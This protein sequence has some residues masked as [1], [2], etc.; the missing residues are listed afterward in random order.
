MNAAELRMFDTKLSA[1]W[2][3]DKEIRPT[4]FSSD[5]ANAIAS[6]DPAERQKDAYL[7]AVTYC[8]AVSI[9]MSKIKCGKAMID[10]IHEGNDEYMPDYPPMSP[11]THS[12]FYSRAFMT[13]RFG[14]ESETAIEKIVQL[15]THWKASAE[16]INVMR[17][18]SHSRM[19]IF[20]TIDIM[21]QFI[22][23]RELLTE[24]EFRLQTS[25]PHRAAVGE[26]RLI[27][28]AVPVQDDEDC[29]FEI[30]TPYILR[31]HSAEQWTRCLESDLP[32]SD[33]RPDPLYGPDIEHPCLPKSET[34]DML[35]A[36]FEN[37]CGPMPWFEFVMDGYSTHT[38][39]SITLSGIPDRLETLPHN[40]E[41]DPQASKRS[42]QGKKSSASTSNFQYDRDLHDEHEDVPEEEPAEYFQML[43][44]LFVNSPEFE[45]LDQDSAEYSHLLFELAFDYIGKIPARFSPGDFSELLFQIIP[46]KVS[47][48]SDE[49]APLVKEFKAFFDF[50]AREFSSLTAARLSTLCDLSAVK[51]L[52]SALGDSSNFGMAKSFFS[53]GAA[54]GFDMTSQEELQKFVMLYNAHL[55]A[56]AENRQIDD[57]ENDASVL[58]LP[59]DFRSDSQ[60]PVLVRAKQAIGRNESCPCGSGKKYK[61]CC[62]KDGDPGCT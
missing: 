54:A 50:A 10:E 49:A 41:Y 14:P 7:R 60:A 12:V 6:D 26:L 23:V 8:M 31:G 28:V 51:K 21:D 1:L 56:G 42:T 52:E 36:M 22:T 27:R 37:D 38:P 44:D 57:E 30:T 15:L 19:G 55:A 11:V 3:K 35:A 34:A 32:D 5:I 2:R 47:I 33:G 13:F 45:E 62:L 4:Q 17:R 43:G 39:D 61:K 40:D 16:A 58:S 25:T 24:R 53:A 20:Q 46:R 59:G 48:D 29:F 18:L 9:E